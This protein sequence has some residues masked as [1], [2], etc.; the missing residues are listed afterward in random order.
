MNDEMVAFKTSKSK[1]ELAWRLNAGFGYEHVPSML[2]E[3]NGQVYFGTKSGVTYAINP[4]SQ[5]VTWAYKLDNSMI[6]TV[7]VIGKNKVIVASM[8]GKVAVL[9]IK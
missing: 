3:N 6:N 8:D 2:I 5:K 7:N 1:G 9:K 4:I